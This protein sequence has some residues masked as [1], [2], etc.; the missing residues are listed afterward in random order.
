MSEKYKGGP[1]CKPKALL[2]GMDM[3]MML[4]WTEKHVKTLPSGHT[5]EHVVAEGQTFVLGQDLG[6]FGHVCHLDEGDQ[7]IRVLEHLP[8]LAHDAQILTPFL[9]YIQ[10]QRLRLSDARKGPLN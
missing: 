5:I 7:L 2:E 9:V 4:S 10:P 8:E 1:Y 3:D 6:T